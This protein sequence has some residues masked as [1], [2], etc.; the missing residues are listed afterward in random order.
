MS[1][2]SAF[3]VALPT[4]FK[5][6]DIYGTNGGIHVKCHP[7]LFQELVA[8]ARRHGLNFVDSY[9]M[10]H[11]DYYIYYKFENGDEY[12]SLFDQINRAT[13]LACKIH[14][15]TLI[16]HNG[17]MPDDV[18]DKLVRLLEGYRVCWTC[19]DNCLVESAYQC[20]VADGLGRTR[21]HLIELAHACANKVKMP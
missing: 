10:S 6:E 8:I 3:H 1:R 4:V 11:D 21:F 9:K 17:G 12:N 18:R 2:R 5:V 19:N 7:S 16:E 20:I 13:I 14:A 15:I